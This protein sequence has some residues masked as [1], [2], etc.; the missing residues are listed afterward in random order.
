MNAYKEKETKLSA[1]ITSYLMSRYGA[2]GDPP[3]MSKNKPT[4]LVRVPTKKI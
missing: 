2:T 4:E 1:G 3:Q